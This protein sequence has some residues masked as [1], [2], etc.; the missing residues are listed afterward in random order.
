MTR[1]KKTITAA[2]AL[3]RLQADP[4]YVEMQAKRD[5]ERAKHAEV[6]R[7][8]EEPL[9]ADLRASGWHVTS[10]WDL[11]NT[12]KPYRTAIP[13]LLNHLTRQYPDRI[14]EGIA[15]ALAVRDA[16]YAWQML[17]AEYL[18]VPQGTG[19]KDGLAAALAEISSE[20]VIDELASLAKDRSN[21]SSRLLLLSGLRR[22]NS[23]VARSALLEL[24]HDPA[25]AKEINSWGKP[26]N[27]GP[28]Y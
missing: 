15:R 22:S 27:P 13:V 2:E 4:T 10:V 12:S 8:E 20:K 9:L 18:S 16:A 24:K 26:Q 7:I 17:V 19:V 1:E 23:I 14:R 11:V 21:G 5:L 6:Q 3:A 25:L 28:R